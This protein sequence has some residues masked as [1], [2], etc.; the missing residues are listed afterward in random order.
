M[1]SPCLLYYLRANSGNFVKHPGSKIKETFLILGILAHFRHFGCG[2]AALC[3][4]GESNEKLNKNPDK[5]GNPY[6]GLKF[7]PMIKI[8]HPW[9]EEK[10]N[11]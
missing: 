10:G 7:K 5:A 2:S 6:R 8:A 4:C 3:L 11:L 1:I 9:A